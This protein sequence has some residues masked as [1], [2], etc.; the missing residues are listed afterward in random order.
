MNIKLL[1][2][3]FAA[4]GGLS[5]GILSNEMALSVQKLDFLALPAM[6]EDPL[7]DHDALGSFKC[8][9]FG[10]DEETGEERFDPGFCNVEYEVEPTEN[11]PGIPA[12]GSLGLSGNKLCLWEAH[13]EDYGEL[14]SETEEGCSSEFWLEHSDPNSAD[15][16]WPPGYRPDYEYSS[17]FHQVFEIEKD[18]NEIKKIKEE[19]EMFI[20]NLIELPGNKKIDQ[21]TKS[22]I[23]W[24]LKNIPSSE[25][26]DY[27][28][29]SEDKLGQFNIHLLELVSKEQLSHEDKKYLRE[30]RDDFKNDDSHDDSHDDDKFTL[31]DALNMKNYLKHNQQQIAKESATAILNA[32][33]YKVNYHY[34][35][36]EVMSITHDA[37]LSEDYN[38]YAKEFKK[39]NYVGR[40]SLCS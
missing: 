13:S 8:S 25:E 4:V 28:L 5:Y 37:I 27:W 7:A 23:T 31:L 21:N 12:E 17:I 32:A 20:D 16:V 35:V 40:S 14:L 38:S 22:T 34:S 26:E 10:T 24:L 29:I 1:F 19:Y 3:L 9:C 39:Y 2:I 6:D 33:H 15:Y 18:Q 36:P 30:I 11:D